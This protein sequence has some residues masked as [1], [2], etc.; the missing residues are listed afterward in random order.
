MPHVVTE[1]CFGCKHTDCLV[2]CPVDCF[3]EGEQMLYIH[4]E[5][6]TD[7]G[8]CAQECPT[9]AIFYEDDVP[10]TWR[11]YIALNAEMAPKCPQITQQK[12][13]LAGRT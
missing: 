6:C 5:E 7:C 13:P 3:Y 1:P 4:P 8:A 2:V 9:S 12:E 11:A 10:E